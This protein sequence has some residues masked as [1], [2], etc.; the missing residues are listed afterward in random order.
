MP[1]CWVASSLG[2]APNATGDVKISNARRA[3]RVSIHVRGFGFKGVGSK[4]N[5]PVVFPIVITVIAV[6]LEGKVSFVKGSMETR[7]M[8]QYYGK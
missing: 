7:L 4:Q 6:D 2:V 3:E 1:D 8:G 5:P